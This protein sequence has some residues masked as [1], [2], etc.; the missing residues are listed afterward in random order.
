MN[1]N[2]I[3]DTICGIDADHVKRIATDAMTMVNVDAC[4]NIVMAGHIAIAPPDGQRH[5][6]TIG[7][8]ECIPPYPNRFVIHVVN[9]DDW[10]FTLYHE[11]YHVYEYVNVIPSNEFACDEFARVLLSDCR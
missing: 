11:L 9:N 7:L 6:R 1:I 5:M 8:C 10:R 3:D 2:V 4:V